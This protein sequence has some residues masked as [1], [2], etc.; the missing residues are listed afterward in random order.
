V[1][2][3]SHGDFYVKFKLRNKIDNFE[4]ILIAVYGAA[5]SEYKE[6][7]LREL[8]HSC[9]IESLPLS[10]GGDFN[11]IRSPSVT[12]DFKEQN[13]MYTICVPR[14]QSHTYDDKLQ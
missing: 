11:I 5:Q 6:S 14:N 2:N 4:W 12:P 8:V 13:Q 3:I 1:G 10:L 9:S 7:F